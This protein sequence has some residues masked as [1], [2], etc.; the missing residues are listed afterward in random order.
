MGIVLELKEIP[1]EIFEE[2]RVVLDAGAGEPNAGLLIEGQFFRLGLL[3][4]LLPGLFRQEYQAE[5]V[6]INTLLRWQGFRRQMRHELMPRKPEHDRVARL[7]TQRTTKPIDIEP[8]RRR[9]IVRRK[10]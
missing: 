6:R 7:P 1:G 3:Q 5:M 2:E 4:E 9:H 10:G 8:F